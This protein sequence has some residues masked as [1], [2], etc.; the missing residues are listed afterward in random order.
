EMSYMGDKDEDDDSEAGF[1]VSPGIGFDLGKVTVTADYN[2]GNE[3]WTWFAL[4][5][6]YRF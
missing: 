3:D 1:Y 4:N 6:A 2:L 5:A